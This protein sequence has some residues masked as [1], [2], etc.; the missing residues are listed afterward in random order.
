MSMA[1]PFDSYQDPKLQP[2]D[3]DE[4]LEDEDGNELMCVEVTYRKRKC[5]HFAVGYYSNGD[6]MCKEHIDFN[7]DWDRAE[8]INDRA[9]DE[10]YI[11]E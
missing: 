4:I 8:A 7:I 11:D 9:R 6:P 10:G 3:E 5:T 1:G 2:P